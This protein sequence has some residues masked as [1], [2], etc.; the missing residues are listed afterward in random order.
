MRKFTHILPLIFTIVIG[1]ITTC[2]TDVSAKKR[3][4]KDFLYKEGR[5]LMLNGKPYQCVS[6]N[7]FQLCG[8]GH[9]Y[10]LFSD[11]EIDALFASLPKNT[12]IRTWAFK[13]FSH[14]TDMLI[15]LAERHKIKLILSL[16]DG[17]SSCG[18]HDG[19]PRGDNSGKVAEWYKSGYRKIYLP[20]V[21][22]MVSRYKE[23]P[24]IA[25]WEIINEPADAPWYVIRDFLH[26][27]AA[28]IKKHDPNHLVESGTFAGWAYEGYENYKALHDSPHIDVGNLHEYDYDYQNSNMIESPHFEACL[29][30]MYDLNK[31]LIVGEVGIESG[32][33]CRTSRNKRVEAMKEKFDIYI[34][35]GAGAVFVW[36][37]AKDSRGCNL[38]F[39]QKDPLYN[40]I[41]N[42]PINQR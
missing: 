23:S 16:G 37:F 12:I 25:M 31:V 36:N 7:S 13:A 41:L 4:R 33:N 38:T 42:Y 11:E 22:E 40:A 35:M 21:I 1:V 3:Y 32:D 10:E 19:A 29:K 17:R 9:D 20:H 27:M 5:Q 30:A 6:F 26:E 34:G 39:N 18:D 28:I 14:K 2:P 8:C 24:A 15:R